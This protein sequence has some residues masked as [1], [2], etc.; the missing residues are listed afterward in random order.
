MVLPIRSPILAN[1]IQAE[2]NVAMPNMGPTGLAGPTTN[3][4]GKYLHPEHEMVVHQVAKQKAIDAVLL[5]PGFKE[6]F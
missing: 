4:K 1:Q 6:R 2:V 3:R 5:K